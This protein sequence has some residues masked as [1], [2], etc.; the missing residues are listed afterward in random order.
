MAAT[1]IHPTD[2]L[3]AVS[4][5]AANAVLALAD[6]LYWAA[7]RYARA[8][9]RRA[10]HQMHDAGAELEPLSR[11]YDELMAQIGDD[12]LYAR[13]EETVWRD[14]RAEYAHARQVAEREEA[15]RG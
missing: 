2:V 9:A 1:A 12:D 5:P 4:D 8:E 3:V 7:D 11:R 14:R 13:I 6:A 15:S 10:R